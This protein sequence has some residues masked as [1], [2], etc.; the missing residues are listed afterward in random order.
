M[1]API[2]NVTEILDQVDGCCNLSLLKMQLVLVLVMVE[3]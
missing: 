2:Y 3:R 1:A